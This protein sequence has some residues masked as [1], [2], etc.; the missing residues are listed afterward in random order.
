MRYFDEVARSTPPELPDSAHIYTYVEQMPT[1]N[2]QSSFANIVTAINQRLVVPP[3]APE[4]RV[5]VRFIVSKRGWVSH[6]QIVKSL[7][8][9]LD[10]AVVAATWQLPRFA[11]GR[12]GGQVVLVSYTLPIIIGAR[13]QP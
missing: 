4:G 6:P 8:P 1:L 5:F 2:G 12:H 3:L 9:D 13:Q 11:P 7:R 10:S